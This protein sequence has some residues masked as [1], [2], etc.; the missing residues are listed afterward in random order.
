MFPKIGFLIY[1][2]KDLR[3][4]Q[5][6]LFYKQPECFA[7]VYAYTKE[8]EQFIAC[9]QTVPDQCLHMCPY[10]KRKRFPKHS[11]GKRIMGTGIV[12]CQFLFS[13]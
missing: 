11:Q 12:R 13:C 6:N 8:D 4:L 7:N 2:S 9:L 3:K 1:K 10:R 5:Q